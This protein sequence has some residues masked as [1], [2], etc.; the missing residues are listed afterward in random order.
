MSQANVKPN[1]NYHPR[2]EAPA[3]G[4]KSPKISYYADHVTIRVPNGQWNE[5]LQEQAQSAN[6]RSDPRAVAEL[7]ASERAQPSTNQG[8]ATPARPVLQPDRRDAIPLTYCNRTRNIIAL[9]G[10]VVSSATILG[11]H[12]AANDGKVPG[13]QPLPLSGGRLSESFLDHPIGLGMYA[14][15]AIAVFAA[16]LLVPIGLCYDDE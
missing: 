4:L 3:T 5:A 9:V 11:V 13:F 16:C 6:I 7:V 8:A 12:V 15:C 14:S 2:P 1:T 10:F